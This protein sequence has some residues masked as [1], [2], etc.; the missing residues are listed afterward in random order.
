MVLEKKNG[1]MG[2]WRS[3][4]AGILS[5]AAPFFPFFNYTCILTLKLCRDGFHAMLKSVVA[6]GHTFEECKEILRTSMY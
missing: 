6:N 3:L 1:E 4:Q 2:I 5:G